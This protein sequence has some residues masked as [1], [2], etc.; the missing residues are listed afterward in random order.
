[1]EVLFDLPFKFGTDHAE[2]M[3][4]FPCFGKDALLV[5]YD[6]P[7]NTRRP[8]PNAVFADVFRLP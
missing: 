1:L 3:T 4:I 2:G 5:V 8:E 7:D 6:S